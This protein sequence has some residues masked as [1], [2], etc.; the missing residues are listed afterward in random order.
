MP[1]S[2]PGR[3]DG[4]TNHLERLGFRLLRGLG[5]CDKRRMV[6]EPIEDRRMGRIR[7]CRELDF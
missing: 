4:T 7:Y 6:E 1:T 2:L 5:A 3:E